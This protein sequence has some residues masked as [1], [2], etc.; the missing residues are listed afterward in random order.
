MPYSV[1]PLRREIPLEPEAHRRAGRPSGYDMGPD[2]FA[3]EMDPLWLQVK[4]L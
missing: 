2:D 4:P 1:R 3:A